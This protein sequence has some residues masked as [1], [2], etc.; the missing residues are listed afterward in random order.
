MRTIKRNLSYLLLLISYLFLSSCSINKQISRSA[1]DYVIN[2]KA[3]QAAHVGISIFDPAE[4]KYLYNYQGHKYFVPASNTKIPTCYAAMKYLGD[5]LVGLR[6]KI[7]IDED[8]D[9]LISLEPT[10]DPSFLHPDFISQPVFRFLQ[11]NKYK[12]NFVMPFFYEKY[13]GSGWSWNDAQETYMA[14]RSFFPIYG[15]TVRFKTENNGQIIAIPDYF[16]KQTSIQFNTD[17]KN[18]ISRQDHNNRFTFLKAKS[19]DVIERIQL[20][21]QVLEI[22]F[23]PEKHLTESLLSDTLQKREATYDYSSFGGILS[24][25]PRKIINPSTIHSQPTDSLLKPMMHRSDNFFAEQSL[26]MVSNEM[27]GVMNDE[28]IIDTLLKTDF[29]DLPQKPRWADGSGL[30]RYNLFTPQSLISILN[31]M[32]NE[33][34]MERIKEIFPTG[35]EGTISS[36]YKADSGYIYAKTGTLSGVVAFSGFLYTKKGKLLIFSTLVNNHQSSATAVR[37]V[38]EKFIQNIR[39]KY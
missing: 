6:Y 33:F 13:F 28:K 10:G 16:T 35:G 5:S 36:Y 26:L 34:G 37:R 27:L 39:N 18:K 23:L 19:D 22:P 24:I 4:N 11:K 20:S 12:L 1:T 3:L 21:K 9:T 29:K 25:L 38:I 30:S 31:K 7:W 32:K 14:P 15:N 8:N 2:N 17:N